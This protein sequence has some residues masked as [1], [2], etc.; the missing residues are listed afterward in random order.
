MQVADLPG[1]QQRGAHEAQRELEMRRQHERSDEA[2]QHGT[3]RAAERDHQ[4][5]ACQ[6]ARRG[7]EPDELAVAEHAADEEAGAEHADLEYEL[8]RELRVGLPPAHHPERRRRDREQDVAPVPPRR[9][10]AED[11]REE[12][13]RERCDPQERDRRDVHA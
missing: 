4:V 13:D 6:V 8:V 1:E 10:E 12:V 7:L 11:E 5:E 2:D 9:V 3:E